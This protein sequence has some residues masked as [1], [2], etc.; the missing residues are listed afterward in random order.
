MLFR[1]N[2]PSLKVCSLADHELWTLNGRCSRLVLK[3]SICLPHQL[4]S[5]D[6]S[7]LLQRVAF[8]LRVMTSH[9]SI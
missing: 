3:I 5:L 4:E 2:S 7:A 1:R 9:V 6:M 8:E